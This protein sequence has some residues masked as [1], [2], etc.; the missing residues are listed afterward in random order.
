M[1]DDVFSLDKLRG[2]FADFRDALATK[3]VAVHSLSSGSKAHL[4]TRI[5]RFVLY[6]V[7]DRLAARSMADSLSSYGKNFVYIPEKDDLLLHRK[8][9]TA[10]N[11]HA[12]L[13]ALTAIAQG[14]ANGAVV[15]AEGLLQTFPKA[16]RVKSAC[17]TLKTGDE[18]E[19]QDLV[20]RLVNAGYVA[21]ETVSK[22]GDVAARGDI[23]DIFPVNF[24]KPVRLSFFDVEIEEIRSF[25]PE[26]GVSDETL[27][28]LFI[29][30]ASDFLLTEREAAAAVKRLNALKVT[31]RT[32]EIVSD[33]VFRLGLNR[34]DGSLVWAVPFI[35]EAFSTLIEH[36][37]DSAVIIFDEPSLIREKMNLFV[38]EH[39]ARVKSLSAAGEVTR[40]HV[41][42]L[43]DESELSAAW[44]GKR[45]V[46]FGQMLTQ[47]PFFD[48]RAIYSVKSQAVTRYYLDTDN[49]VA[50]LKVFINGGKLVVLCCGSSERA[51]AVAK[52]LL[53]E[54]VF[55]AEENSF[56]DRS[57][58][59]ATDFR[60]KTGFFYPDAN[61]VVVGMD[62]L[63]GKN[64]DVRATKH[65]RDFIAP[66]IGDYVV[67]RVH[68]IGICTGTTRYKINDV[69]KDFIVLQYKGG[70][71][72]FVATD[73]MDN[74]EKYSGA[75]VPA[76]SKIGGKEFARVKDKVKQSVHKLAMDLLRVYAER[77]KAQ[78][79]V[80]SP[81]SELQEEFERGF[82]Y[83]ETQDQLDAVAAIKNEMERGKVMDR[84]I[85]GDVGF[86]KTEV[87]LRAV[88]KTIL[89]NRQAAILAPTTI[90]TRQ[91]YNTLCERLEPFG[92]GCEILS[93][94][95]TKQEI[96]ASLKRLADGT[97]LVAVA[98]HRL[99]SHDVVFKDLGLLVLDE[100]Q[101]FGVEHKEQLKQKYPMLNVLTLSATPIPRTLNMA[102]TG[103]RD[104]SLL[105]TPPEGRLPI[106]T[107][108]A[109][110]SDGLVVDAVRR[111][112]AR[113]GQVFVLY[114]RVESIDHY[115]ASLQALLGDEIRI[116]VG[117]GQLDKDSLDKRMTA[118]YAG[119]ADVLVATTIIENGIDLPSANTLI[120][121]EADRFG[122]AQLYQLRGRVGRS[123]ALAHAYFTT[124]QGKIVS[125]DAME[126]LTALL[127][128]TEL[129]SGFKIAMRDLELRGAG[130][131][132][133]A[134]QH[135]HID[136][137][138]YQMYVRLLN[139]AVRELRGEAPISANDVK[140]FVDADTYIRESYVSA[141][142][143]LKI[144]KQIAEV[145]SFSQRDA[146]LGEL[147][148]IYG[149]PEQP[150]VNLV[151]AALLKNLAARVDAEKVTINR[152]GAG[153]SFKGD[154][155]WKNAELLNA[156][157]ECKDSVVLTDT[158]P[159][160]LV[161]NVR[162]FTA[163]AKIIA[164]LD[165]LGRVVF[166]KDAA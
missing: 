35:R 158:I 18:I 62:E 89:D 126:R 81:D 117:H 52:Q 13:S 131:I 120:V 108:I 69:E 135:G 159:P 143:K 23:V 84:L 114:N 57:H 101:R 162:G 148:D 138:G 92:A 97:S 123:G 67:H 41:R 127:D 25:D 113:G 14:K 27:D 8:A 73:Q 29:S 128:N 79:Y 87:A 82:P 61:L 17:T 104:I 15:S 99:L 86:G 63:V 139:E 45:L 26:T 72:L 59:I 44:Q 28:R 110:Y 141:R 96:A 71:T 55:A 111:E 163:E 165:F 74:L 124:A 103:I 106:Q 145:D 136:K 11:V 19:I 66:K 93:R 31:G 142:D 54:G 91:H 152:A 129:G 150:L 115:A 164:V 16:A 155:L 9:F 137:V 118:F 4:A 83:D 78:G 105:E 109:E 58:V 166:G 12:R 88:F 51:S 56:S 157:A 161:F 43:F 65:K 75:D 98:T 100:E 107:Y 85:C 125:A 160:Q 153:I 68:G 77:E 10:D 95:Q 7:P 32:A 130:D 38:E 53:S 6:V 49:L 134:E 154:S 144:Y 40:E 94:F 149:T 122:L 156:V 5:S 50:D 39:L 116:I 133:G 21:G 70:D 1:I 146:L 48:P 121:C 20:A 33:V 2:V 90:L 102:L 30:P 34:N 132:L 80:Y 64:R 42:S 24:A 47:N 112:V 46:S 140:L 119:E 76:L 36:L 151:N 22:K 147:A 3:N 60:V 37:P